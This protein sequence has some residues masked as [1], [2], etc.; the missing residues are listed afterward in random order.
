MNDY[1]RIAR[2]IEYLDEHYTEHPELS[3]LARHV[4][5]SPFHFHRLFSTWAGVSPKDFIQCLTLNHAKALL[6]QGESVLETA[7]GVGLSGPGRL[8]DLC[9]RLEGASPGEMKSRGAGFEIRFGFAETPFGKWLA[10]ENERGVCHLAFVEEGAS[11]GALAVL[12]ENWSMARLRRDDS[13]A[14]H[15]ASQV[16][17]IP[18]PHEA[19]TVLRAFVCGT[20]FQLRVWR[21]LLQ[22]PPGALVSYGRLAAAIGE[23]KAARAVGTAVGQNSLAFLIPCHRIIRETGIVG[24]YRWGKTRKHAIIGWESRAAKPP[25]PT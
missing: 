15:L 3:V 10:A 8:H 1:E 11:S 2:V 19:R 22:V 9:V 18:K 25:E 7:L 24:Q 14:A 4:G 5:L 23:P 13:V 20:S 21:A 6:R 17:Q 16:F 12:R